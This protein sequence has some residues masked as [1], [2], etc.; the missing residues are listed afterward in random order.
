M[1][2]SVCSR[3]QWNLSPED[4][5]VYVRA[6]FKGNFWLGQ[7]QSMGKKHQLKTKPEM[8]IHFSKVSINKTQDNQSG[9]VEWMLI[10]RPYATRVCTLVQDAGSVQPVDRMGLAPAQIGQKRLNRTVYRRER[11]AGLQ[12]GYFFDSLMH[13]YRFPDRNALTTRYL[14]WDER[15]MHWSKRHFRHFSMCHTAKCQRLVNL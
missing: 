12:L 14:V 1:M 10:W 13:F 8:E 7:C 2:S 9:G 4:E 15:N 11:R 6:T 3:V 5:N